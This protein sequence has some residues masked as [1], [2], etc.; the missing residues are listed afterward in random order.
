MRCWSVAKRIQEWEAVDTED[1]ELTRYL[2]EKGADTTIGDA[3]W[4]GQGNRKIIKEEA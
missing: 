3:R 1:V 4:G 2:L